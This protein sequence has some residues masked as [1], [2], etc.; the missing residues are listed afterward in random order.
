M[1]FFFLFEAGSP[2][3]QAGLELCSYVVEDDPELQSLLLLP[4]E[5]QNDRCPPPSI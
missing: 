5:Y 4:T 1:I 2:I 3:S